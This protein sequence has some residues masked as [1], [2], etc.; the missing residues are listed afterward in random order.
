MSEFAACSLL[1]LLASLVSIAAGVAGGALLGPRDNRATSGLLGGA[2]TAV[3]TIPGLVIGFAVG[4][5]Q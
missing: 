3:A 5:L 1:L 2:L 4:L